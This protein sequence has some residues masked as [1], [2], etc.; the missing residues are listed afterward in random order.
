MKSLV[1]TIAGLFF[2]RILTAQDDVFSKFP[3]YDGFSKKINPV[4][5]VPE[6]LWD[7]IDGAADAYLGFG[8]LDLHMAYYRKNKKVSVRV[9][10]YRHS[11]RNNSFGVYA[12]ERFPDYH[13]INCGVQGYQQGNILNFYSDIYYVKIYGST[14][15]EPVIKAMNDIAIILSK[16]LGGNTG[17]PEVL[18]RFP[19]EGK[20]INKESYCAVNFMGYNFYNSVFVSEYQSGENVFRIFLLKEGN[21][22]ECRKIINKHFENAGLVA[23]EIKQRVI[24]IPDP[25]NGKVWLYWK[26][27]EIWGITDLNDDDIAQK[28]LKLISEE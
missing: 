21:Q 2:L 22:E 4:V 13:F 15:E 17:Y 12:N 5:Y 9:E 8:F 19:I 10:I 26:A 25:Y 20:I 23:G 27:D 7:Y 6:N 1:F 16:N 11:D 18:K 24:N 14:S 3:E 28:Y